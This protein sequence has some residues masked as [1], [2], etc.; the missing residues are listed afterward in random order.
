[1][2]YDLP[3]AIGAAASGPA[4]GADFQI[5]GSSNEANQLNTPTL[6]HSSTPLF[7]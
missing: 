7:R 5:R 6:T 1:M 4:G 3:F 2:I